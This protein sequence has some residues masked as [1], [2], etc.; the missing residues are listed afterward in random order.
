MPLTAFGI[1]KIHC[2]WFN[3]VIPQPLSHHAARA[4]DPP[5]V[6]TTCLPCLPCA[7]NPP[8]LGPMLALSQREL[9]VPRD[10][11]VVSTM[12][13]DNRGNTEYQAGI[14]N[15]S[16]PELCGQLP[17]QSREPP[18]SL[19]LFPLPCQPREVWNSINLPA[20]LENGGWGGRRR[21]WVAMVMAVRERS[22]TAG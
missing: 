17:L 12:C 4:E 19:S 3:Q 22:S 7:T 11:Q 18:F 5:S 9:G 13:G 2:P 15:P 8:P 10:P 14:R 20:A 1:C 6:W 21:Q 16:Q